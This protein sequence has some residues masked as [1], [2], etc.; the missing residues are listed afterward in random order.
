MLTLDLRVCVQ[1]GRGMFPAPW[2][3]RVLWFWGVMGTTFAVLMTVWWQ[4]ARHVS[5]QKVKAL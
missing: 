2:L 4:R 5:R 1:F 3:D